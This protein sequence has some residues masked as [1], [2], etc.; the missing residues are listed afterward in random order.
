M[1]SKRFYNFPAF[2][3]ARDK[4]VAEG[5]EVQSPADMDREHGFDATSLAP[6]S[7]WNK[8]PDGFDFSACIDRDIAAVKW[9]DAI[10]MLSGWQSSKGA[11]AEL[12]LAQWIGK[13]VIYQDSDTAS[14]LPVTPD[15]TTK[16][17]NPKDAL[18][19]KK[20]PMH[21]WPTTATALGSIGML[22]GMLKYGR[23]NFRAIGVRASIYYDAASRH[24]NAW[25]EGEDD[26]PDDGVP[27][28]AAALSC[29][30]II[31]DAQAANKL[32]DDRVVGGNYRK[33]IDSISGH[34]PRLQTLHKA[35][36]PKHWTIADNPK[37]AGK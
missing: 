26:D 14:A 27:H 6:G 16:P 29:L 32:T 35:R 5:H 24:L 9:C 10:Y 30:A 12:T 4:L 36:S 23:S 19:S 34:V 13:Q 28:L 31:V 33:F 17:S 22:N 7:D 21:L 20:L 15:A 1:R 37:V 18:G 3:A 25:F 8:I 11:S 2:D